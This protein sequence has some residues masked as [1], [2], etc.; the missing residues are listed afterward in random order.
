MPL[1]SRGRRPVLD[2][3]GGPIHV[4]GAAARS[5][6]DAAASR[7]AAVAWRV[8]AGKLGSLD[9]PSDHFRARWGRIEARPFCVQPSQQ[10]GLQ[11]NQNGGSEASSWPPPPFG[12]IV[13]SLRCHASTDINKSGRREVAAS[14]RP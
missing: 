12:D 1:L 10:I 9:Q 11:P 7:P 14:F 5:K 13:F 4:P 8:L 6:T 2:H 3:R